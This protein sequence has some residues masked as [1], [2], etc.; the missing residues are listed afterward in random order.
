MAQRHKKNIGDVSEPFIIAVALYSGE[1]KDQSG[2]I[3]KISSIERLCDDTIY[4]PTEDGI[5]IS[6]GNVFVSKDDLRLCMIE[7][8][9]AMKNTD[10]SQEDLKAASKGIMRLLNMKTTKAP[11]GQCDMFVRFSDHSLTSKFDCKLFGASVGNVSLVNASGDFFYITG[12]YSKK[13]KDYDEAM[14]RF[15]NLFSKSS[16]GHRVRVNGV[17]IDTPIIVEQSY[18]SSGMQ[19]CLDLIGGADVLRKI[20]AFYCQ[21]CFN[22]KMKTTIRF[23]DL[24]VEVATMLNRNSSELINNVRHILPV[25]Y[26]TSSKSKRKSYV[27]EPTKDAGEVSL[28]IDTGQLTVCTND[29]AYWYASH[30]MDISKMDCPKIDRTRTM[31]IMPSWMFYDNVFQGGDEVEVTKEEILRRV[32]YIGKSIE[33]IPSNI[34]RFFKNGFGLWEIDRSLRKHFRCDEI[35]FKHAPTVRADKKREEKSIIAS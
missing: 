26:S 27:C 28:N 9:R 11:S 22:G 32:G 10:S 31:R 29:S 33:S 24:L 25:W 18:P 15:S 6:P 1:A 16:S 23:E 5:M 17:A 20:F 35:H 13:C 12:R 3:R 8:F 14:S 4:E 30:L 19:E 21:Q 34:I 2:A 7:M